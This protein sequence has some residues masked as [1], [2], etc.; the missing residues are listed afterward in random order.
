MSYLHS[1][2]ICSVLAPGDGAN[3]HYTCATSIYRGQRSGLHFLMRQLRCKHDVPVKSPR[4]EGSEIEREWNTWAE[5]VAKTEAER[6]KFSPEQTAR[7]MYQLGI[8]GHPDLAATT[9]EQ[10]NK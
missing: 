4:K 2:P 7:W 10:L 3:Q 8:A 1:C 6:R 5:A 9:G